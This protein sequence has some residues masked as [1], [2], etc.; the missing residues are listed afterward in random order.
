MYG[1]S[2][3]LVD[4]WLGELITGFDRGSESDSTLFLVTAAR[5][6]VWQHVRVPADHASSKKRPSLTDQ[7]IQTPL[8]LKLVNDDRFVSDQSQRSDRLTQSQDL[9]A[10]LLDWFHCPGYPTATGRSYLHELTGEIPGRSELRIISG[11]HEFAVRTSEW[12]A[13]H[14]RNHGEKSVAPETLPSPHL[15]KKPEDIW[16]INDVADQNPEIVSKLI[17]PLN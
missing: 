6:H 5:G 12:L 7:T 10:T 17:V 11:E 8:I 16:D 4:H 9:M 2:V 15:F 14:G 3:S 1:G 13:I